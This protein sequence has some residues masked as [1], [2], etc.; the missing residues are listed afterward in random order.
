MGCGAHHLAI[1]SELK[2]LRCPRHSCQEALDSL[3]LEALEIPTDPIDGMS[4]AALE[5]A[6]ER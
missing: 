4:L 3:Q 1:G 6:F 2:H 5:L